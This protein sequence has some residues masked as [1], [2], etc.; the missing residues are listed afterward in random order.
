ML[1][2]AIALLFH[3]PDAQLTI[4]PEPTTPSFFTSKSRRALALKHRAWEANLGIA[5]CKITPAIVKMGR[6][7]NMKRE[8]VVFKGERP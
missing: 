4:C 6:R 2:P 5:L 8:Q 7:W 3:M 1:R